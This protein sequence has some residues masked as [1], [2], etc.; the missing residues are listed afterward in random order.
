MSRSNTNI[1]LLFAHEAQVFETN[2]S[3]DREEKNAGFHTFFGIVKIFSNLCMADIDI[4]IYKQLWYDSK[5][6]GIITKNLG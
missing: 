4:K 2:V 3:L 1:H 5:M 6:I